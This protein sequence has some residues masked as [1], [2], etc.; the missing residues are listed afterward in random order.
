MIGKGMDTETPKLK[1]LVKIV[2]LQQYLSNRGANGQIKAKF[3]TVQ[4]TI[5]SFMLNLAL[6]REEGGYRGTQT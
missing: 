3:G 2:F 4:Y 6:S 1:N 5:G